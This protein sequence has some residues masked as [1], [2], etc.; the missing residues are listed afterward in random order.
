MLKY[1]SGTTYTISAD[2]KIITTTVFAGRSPI[3][4][5]VR[6]CVAKLVSG[7]IEEIVIA[8]DDGSRHVITMT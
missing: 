6:S 1:Q 3:T 2:E 5:A 7:K 4:E 8:G